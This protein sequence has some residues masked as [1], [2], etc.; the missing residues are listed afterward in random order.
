MIYNITNLNA[1]P[2][3][4]TDSNQANN[5]RFGQKVSLAKTGNGNYALISA[6]GANSS[7][8]KAY[9]FQGTNFD[10]ETDVTAFD[11]STQMEYG[12]SLDFS[13]TNIEFVISAPA[14]NSS[15]INPGVYIHSTP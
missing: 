11:V 1:T 12:Y 6:T 13:N 4:I 7:A 9:I 2:I 14:S 5:N 8:G 15:I 10:V 3:E